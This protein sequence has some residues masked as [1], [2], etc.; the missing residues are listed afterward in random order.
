MAHTALPGWRPW[1]ATRCPVVVRQPTLLVVRAAHTSRA[2]DGGPGTVSR[3]LLSVVTGG[4][5]P[6]WYCRGELHDLISA[7]DEK[8]QSW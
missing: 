1:L 8:E 2:P 7:S 6:P 4:E 3:L 5:R